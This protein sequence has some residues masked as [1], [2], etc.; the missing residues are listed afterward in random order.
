[1][2]GERV[3]WD[4]RSLADLCKL[5]KGLLFEVRALLCDHMTSLPCF[6]ITQSVDQDIEVDG[7]GR[8]EVIFI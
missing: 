5:A 1:M 4:L 2:L 7:I 8:I 6:E 3:D